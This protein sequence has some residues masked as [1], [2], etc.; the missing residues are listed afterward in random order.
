MKRGKVVA[1]ILVAAL[2]VGCSTTGKF[3]V[4]SGTELEIYKRP[5][6]PDARGVVATKPFFWTAAGGVKYRLLKGGEV[7]KAG[8]LRAKFRVVSLF[9]PP[10]AILYWPMGLNGNI[11][12][13]LKRDTQQ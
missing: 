13:D 2:L 7:V 3:V 1:T 9:W 8:K 5:V 6:T 10:F 11:T 4:P 12:Y